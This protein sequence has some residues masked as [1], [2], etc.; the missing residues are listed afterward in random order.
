MGQ[1]PNWTEKELLY[2]EE[3]WGQVTTVTIAKKLNRTVSAVKQKAIRRG[4][5]PQIRSS[6]Y[7]SLVDI[8][9]AFKKEYSSIIEIWVKNNGLKLKLR[10]FVETQRYKVIKPKDFWKW[11]EQNKGLLNFAKYERYALP[12]EPKWLKDKI[13][14]DYNAQDRSRISKLWTSSE[15]DSLRYM[16]SSGKHTIADMAQV[17]NR[18]ETAIKRRAYDLGFDK[19]FIRSKN[20]KYTETEL[21]KLLELAK[22]GL[23]LKALAKAMDRSENSVRGKLERMG[24]HFKTCTFREVPHWIQNRRLR[25][26]QKKQQQAM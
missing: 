2:L 6:A 5:G 7:I 13:K 18:S 14:S 26:Q 3:S 23:S 20:Q 19:N 17:L 24:Y 8:S 10:K 25:R 11:A 22:Q 1:K 15:D 9:R 12:D 4:L 16:Y 21:Q